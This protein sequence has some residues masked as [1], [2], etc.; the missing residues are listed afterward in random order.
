MIFGVADSHFLNEQVEGKFDVVISG[1][2]SLPHVPSDEDLLLAA[3]SI[4][5]KLRGDGL[6]L[7][8]MRGY[9]RV[10]RE[11]LRF[12]MPR[13]LDTPDSGSTSRRGIGWMRAP[14]RSTCSSST[15]PATPGRHT[16]TRS[17]TGPTC[18]RSSPRSC[19]KRA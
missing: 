15:N 9:E 7:A 14:T 13:E 16:T 1:D 17:A 4:R 12:T 19:A 5:S 11:R 6:F 8:S 10:L 18:A 3:Q 2:N